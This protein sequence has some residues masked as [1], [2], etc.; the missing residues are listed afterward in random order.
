MAD[1]FDFVTHG[2]LHDAGTMAQLVERYQEK[3]HEGFVLVIVANAFGADWPSESKLEDLPEFKRIYSGHHSGYYTEKFGKEL[4][5]ARR[6]G[7]DGVFEVR[8]DDVIA[9]GRGEI[10]TRLQTKEPESGDAE[11]P[12]PETDSDAR[13]EEIRKLLW[14]SHQIGEQNREGI[15]SLKERSPIVK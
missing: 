7:P 3:L 15:D 4:H 6:L 11:R 2:M 9:P 14:E 1:E 5:I 13:L 12:E 8:R 10:I